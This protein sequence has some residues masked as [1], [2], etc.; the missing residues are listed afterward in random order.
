MGG[1]ADHDYNLCLPVDRVVGDRD[2][3]EW[4]REGRR[5]FREHERVVGNGEAGFDRVAYVVE[6]DAQDLP[7]RR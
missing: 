7:G 5:E 3:S 2:R 1:L 6:A 4:G